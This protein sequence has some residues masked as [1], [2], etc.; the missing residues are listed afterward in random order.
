MKYS[1]IVSEIVE[2]AIREFPVG[3]PTIHGIRERVYTGAPICY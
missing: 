1:E 2:I 3:F